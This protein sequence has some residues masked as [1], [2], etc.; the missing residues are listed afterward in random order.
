[1]SLF[2]CH[3]CWLLYLGTFLQFLPICECDYLLEWPIIL[4]V[5]S[6]AIVLSLYI[7]VVFLSVQWGLLTVT[8]F[9]WFLPTDECNHF[10]GSLMTS[11]VISW[12]IILSLH[13]YISL[14][15]CWIV[16]Y[17]IFCDYYSS[18]MAPYHVPILFNVALSFLFVS[19]LRNS[20]ST[21][22]YH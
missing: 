22:C 16:W 4:K 19:S 13:Y 14:S 10:L 18:A 15:H 6:W 2:C 7:I 21:L 17:R 12:G 11:E 1:M 5:L 9:L 8:I 3:C 20:V